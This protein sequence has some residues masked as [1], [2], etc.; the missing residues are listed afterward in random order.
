MGLLYGRAAFDLY[1]N[2]PIMQHSRIAY[3]VVIG[4][5][6]LAVICV[7]SLCFTLFFKNYSDPVVIT[8]LIAITG[9]LIGNLGSIL[10]GPMR[11]MMQQ[12][13]PDIT[14][15]GDPPKVEVTANP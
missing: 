6:I 3:I 8:A 2:E 14:V 9:T 7:G 4:Q 11:Q 15:S 5:V 13:Q 12:K 1:M 10:G